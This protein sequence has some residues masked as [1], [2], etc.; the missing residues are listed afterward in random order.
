MSKKARKSKSARSKKTSRKPSSTPKTQQLPISL[1]PDYRAAL[2]A[3]EVISEHGAKKDV[4][5]KLTP[6][7]ARAFNAY[8]WG[9]LL[10]A[11]PIPQF[12]VFLE[13][14]ITENEMFNISSMAMISYSDFAE[15]VG[16]HAENVQDVNLD[17]PQTDGA[18]IILTCDMFVPSGFLGICF[19]IGDGRRVPSLAEIRLF[20]LLSNQLSA[21]IENSR[22]HLQMYSEVRMDKQHAEDLATGLPGKQLFI[23]EL[24]QEIKRSARYGND[25]TCL[26]VDFSS[27]NRIKRKHK[28]EIYNRLLGQ[29]GALARKSIREVDLAARYSASQFAVMLPDTGPAGARVVAHR[30]LASLDQVRVSPGRG[31]QPITVNGG[32]VRV[33]LAQSRKTKE[34]A[35]DIVSRIQGA[36]KKAK[37]DGKKTRVVVA[38]KSA[39]RRKQTA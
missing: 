11:D 21:A 25:L 36:L 12:E 7:I 27:L 2:K 28:S 14:K 9:V 22:L 20:S 6:T 19:L 33:C 3:S 8:G 32:L 1:E 29:L 37:A 10:S 15:M 23:D 26:F 38:P 34:T 17:R 5:K 30:F 39:I 35:K 24:A 4:M 16:E 31:K 13:K 18:D